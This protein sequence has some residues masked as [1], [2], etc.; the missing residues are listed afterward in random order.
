MFLTVV[1]LLGGYYYLII[2]Y[3]SLLGVNEEKVMVKC[4]CISS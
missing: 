1:Y 4:G 3:F 2:T